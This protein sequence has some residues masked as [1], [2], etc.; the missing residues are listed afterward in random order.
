[1]T[2]EA[3]GEVEL[4]LELLV[5]GRDRML[6][7]GV[8]RR[9]GPKKSAL[10]ERAGTLCWTLGVSSALTSELS[11]PDASEGSEE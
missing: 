5:C 8:G 7:G 11:E 10:R 4:S 1:M 6:G 3:G 9:E 2:R